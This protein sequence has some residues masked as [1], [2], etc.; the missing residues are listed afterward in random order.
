VLSKKVRKE[1]T[2]ET[3]WGNDVKEVQ[4]KTANKAVRIMRQTAAA[5]ASKREPGNLDMDDDDETKLEIV[6]FEIIS[7]NMTDKMPKGDPEFKIF[8]ENH[9]WLLE[10]Y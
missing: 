8:K 5:A 9:D 3:D 4:V 6:L 1:N 2:F 10:Y 7:S